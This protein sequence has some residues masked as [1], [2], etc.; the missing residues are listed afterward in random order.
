MEKINGT[1]SPH[2]FV[3]DELDYLKRLYTKEQ[4][5]KLWKD[6]MPKTSDLFKNYKPYI[7]AVGTVGGV[8]LYQVNGDDNFFYIT[9]RAGAE[10]ADKALRKAAIEYENN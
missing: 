5:E 3:V 2:I 1:K 6:V 9:D 10:E 8:E 4:I 7:V